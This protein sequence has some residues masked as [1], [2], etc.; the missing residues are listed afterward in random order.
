MRANP[1]IFFQNGYGVLFKK[2]RWISPLIIK[3][4]QILF[5]SVLTPRNSKQLRILDVGA[6]IGRFSLPLAMLPLPV[7]PIVFAV[8]RSVEMLSVLKT[9]SHNMGLSNI[10]CIE[11]DVL[12]Y[13]AH[14][15]FDF[16][17]LSDVL[18]F[19]MPLKDAFYHFYSLL[20]DGGLICI[21]ARSHDALA[22]IEWLHD[23][24]GLLELDRARV[25]DINDL[26]EMLTCCGFGNIMS[27]E[28]DETESVSCDL[29]VKML[30]E[31]SFSILHCIPDKDFENGLISVR[32]RLINQS[33]TFQTSI[34]TA[35]IAKKET[36][37]D[38]I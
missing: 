15:S 5:V 1:D 17:F 19:L 28:I 13:D 29:Y 21:R 32:K 22:Q 20:C 26:A 8:D 36:S 14:E 25:P 37:N 16:I 27:Y 10:S 31:R 3:K 35:L 33:L 38:T 23:F 24:Q 18:P 9:E 34:S 30:E 2:Y 7:K 4:W 11:S 6:G 12:E